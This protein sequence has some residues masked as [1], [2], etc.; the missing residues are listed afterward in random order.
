MADVEKVRRKRTV[1]DTFT[2][3]HI[4]ALL[5]TCGKDFVGVRDRAMILLLL[6]C[7]LRVSELCGLTMDDIDWT[8][9][10]VLVVGK[11]NVERMVP[12]GATVRQGVD[13]LPVPPGRGDGARGLR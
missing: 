1:L 8:A 10:T 4:D 11:G 2:M 5:A 9:Q 6:D 12:F 3:A 7:G 13:R